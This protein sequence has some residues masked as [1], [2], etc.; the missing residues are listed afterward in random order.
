MTLEYFTAHPH[1]IVLLRLIPKPRQQLSKV[2]FDLTNVAVK[3]VSAKGNR[4]SSR[5]VK[6]VEFLREEA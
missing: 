4:M 3:G 5:E 6:R 2:E 1:H